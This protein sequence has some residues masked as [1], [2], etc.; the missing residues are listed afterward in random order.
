MPGSGVSSEHFNEMLF[1]LTIIHPNSMKL[2]HTK[3]AMST[4]CDK[5]VAVGETLFISSLPK[6]EL[7]C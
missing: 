1:I 6:L 2:I 3:E 4:I 7:Q 5:P